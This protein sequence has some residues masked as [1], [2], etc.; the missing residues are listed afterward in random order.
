[1]SCLVV[2]GPCWRA[3][4]IAVCGWRDLERTSSSARWVGRFGGSNEVVG[5]PF[6]GSFVRVDPQARISTTMGKSFQWPRTRENF[7]RRSDGRFQSSSVAGNVH[8][9]GHGGVSTVA[10]ATS[11]G[12]SVRGEIK[13]GRAREIPRQRV[14][15]V[16]RCPLDGHVSTAIR[17]VDTMC[18]G[19]SSR[20]KRKL[21]MQTQCSQ[22]ERSDH[23]RAS[24]EAVLSAASVL[25]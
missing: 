4:G 23:G 5:S 14:V 11:N 25:R 22:Y 12:S 21:W 6:A 17:C 8:P 3:R 2:V 18:E 10:T 15:S 13:Q 7:D 9:A 24:L 1:M 19:G 20:P 16:G